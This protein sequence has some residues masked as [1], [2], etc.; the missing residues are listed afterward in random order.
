ME[1]TH[2][3]FSLPVK[4][5]RDEGGAGVC[6]ERV[7]FYQEVGHDCRVVIRDQNRRRLQPLSLVGQHVAPEKGKMLASVLGMGIQL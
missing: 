5:E 6:A 1:I 2:K 4:T 3:N 7:G